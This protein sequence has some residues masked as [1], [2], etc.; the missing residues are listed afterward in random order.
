M[1]DDNKQ[2]YIE[3][4]DILPLTKYV[5]SAR[6]YN[7]EKKRWSKF[8]EP[9]DIVTDF[10][11]L[12]SEDL[13]GVNARLMN[14]NRDV[15]CK[16][17]KGSCSI[18]GDIKYILQALLFKEVTFSF[19]MNELAQFSYFGFVEYPMDFDAFKHDI[20]TYFDNGLVVKH[21]NSYCLGCCNGSVGIQRWISGSK[22][23]KKK[24]KIG[25]NDLKLDNGE[26]IK[27]GDVFLFC[28]N[29]DRMICDV[30]VN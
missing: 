24:L 16:S 18:V 6:R 21:P 13:H 29:F 5:I 23:G 17:K 27:N 25:N 20:A 10:K 30:Y 12:W 14:S 9:V 2:Q 8:C 11:C 15:Y 7:S 4:D 19:K 28:V 3:L 22:K 26:K 1:P